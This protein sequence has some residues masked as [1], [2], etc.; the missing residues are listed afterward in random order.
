MNNTFIVANLDSRYPAEVDDI[1]INPPTRGMHL[2]S[3][4]GDIEIKPTLLRSLL[5]QRL[6]LHV[7]AIL[8]GQSTLEPDQM[9]DMAYRIME[10]PFLTAMPSVN[11]IDPIVASASP[12][13]SVTL[14][15]LAERVKDV[16]KQ[17]K[18]LQ[19]RFNARALSNSS[20]RRPSQLHR[21]DFD[22]SILTSLDHYPLQS[23]RYCLT[24]T[25]RFC[26][27]VEAW[28]L[29]SITAEDVAQTL[30]A[31]WISRF[32]SPEKIT[33]DL[34]RQFE[35]QLLKQ[36]GMFTAFKSSCTTSYHPCSN[37]IIERVHRQLKASLMCHTDS[38]WF[39]AI[40]VVL[41][42]ILSV[43]KEDFQSSSVELVYGEPLRLPGKF[44]SP[45]PA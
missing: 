41:L 25:D 14:E 21:Y 31:G 39:E 28:P 43:F 17:V 44:I 38:S 22:T 40:P 42:G 33:S 8:Q 20:R 23:Y 5:L 10:V 3:L 30:F 29:E 9:A 34:G 37:G 45:L 7:Q 32:G 12:R 27:W 1:I 35:S 19:A 6:P 13:V 15:S 36:L 16:A 11:S 4:A 2:R 26:R 24:A 18:L